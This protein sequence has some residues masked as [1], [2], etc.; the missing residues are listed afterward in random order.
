MHLSPLRCLLTLTL[1]VTT[2]LTAAPTAV[3]TPAPLAATTA[4]PGH[5]RRPPCVVAVAEPERM[6]GRLRLDDRGTARRRHPA[7]AFRHGVVS[8]RFVVPRS[9]DRRLTVTVAAHRFRASLV[10]APGSR[11]RLVVRWRTDRLAERGLR[12]RLPAGRSV[13][14]KLGLTGRKV[15]AKAWRTGSAQPAWQVRTTHRRAGKGH[16]RATIGAR[17]LGGGE[18][19][20]SRARVRTIRRTGS[21]GVYN[22]M[23][24]EHRTR[25]QFGRYPA[26]ATSYYQS[27]QAVNVGRERARIRHGT[28]PNITMTTKGTD[29]IEVLGTGPRH[30]RFNRA[31]AWLDRYVRALARVAET[32]P[33]VPV[34]ATI[35]HEFKYKVRTHQVTGRS[36]DPR[37]Y[38]RTLRRFYAAARKASPHLRVTY[39]MVADGSDRALEARV[40]RAFRTPPDAI[41]FD[42]YADR[43]ESLRSITAADVAWIRR[44]PWYVG[45]E[46]ALGEFGMRVV[47]GDPALA[48]FYAGVDGA[49]RR[50]GLSWGVF[51]NRG[52]DLNTQIAGRS[53]GRSFPRAVAA[54]R[55]SLVASARC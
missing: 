10:R 3:P 28:S 37:Y 4:E 34:Y 20:F 35:E 42:P 47:A 50:A 24:E 49:L 7:G 43:G 26:V 6:S 9:V 32:D 17:L 19:R 54:F 33:D 30:P 16:G 8:A 51:F 52:R 18:V 25:Q 13:H 29:L 36:A 40:P 5:H 38:G 55:R 44:Q 27:Y 53:D 39:W 31:K 48:G 23:Y 14:L 21:L 41:L 22:G 11:P 46:I 15:L 12:F 45:Q 1:A 2:V